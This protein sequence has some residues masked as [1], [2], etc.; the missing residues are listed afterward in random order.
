MIPPLDVFS[1]KNDEPTWISAAD[2][3]VH[4][5]EIAREKGTGIYL[6]LSHET[7]HKTMYVVDA[8]GAVQAEYPIPPNN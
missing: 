3:A 2:S 1:I 8:T 7:G 6:V 4:A 5:L